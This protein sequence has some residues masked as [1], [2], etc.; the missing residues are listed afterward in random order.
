MNYFKSIVLGL[1]IL[2]IMCIVFISASVFVE[3]PVDSY[4]VRYSQAV[5]LTCSAEIPRQE[6]LS[7]ECN[8]QVIESRLV[9]YLPERDGVIAASIGKES[10]LNGF[11]G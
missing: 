8:G 2:T 11:W 9:E 3:D 10:G 6:M 1:V 4:V 7:F 5:T